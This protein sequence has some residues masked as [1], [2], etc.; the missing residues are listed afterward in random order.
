MIRDH[1]TTAGSG[2]GPLVCPHAHHS[3]LGTFV[4]VV[5]WFDGTQTKLVSINGQPA[6]EQDG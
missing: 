2:D 5:G 3:V 6:K 4:E 1:N